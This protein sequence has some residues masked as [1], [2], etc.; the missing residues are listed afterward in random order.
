MYL[1]LKAFTKI[2][3][4]KSQKCCLVHSF[5]VLCIVIHY[6]VLLC[7]ILLYEYY[8]IIYYFFYV[9]INLVSLI[10]RPLQTKLLLTLVFSQFIAYFEEHIVRSAI[11]DQRTHLVV[12]VNTKDFSVLVNSICTPIDKTTNLSKFLPYLIL[13]F[14]F[15]QF[16]CVCR[17]ICI[18]MTTN[19]V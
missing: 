9:E 12:V 15:Q 4:C 16:L 11:A 19:V 10:P 1:C 8:S 6:F 17:G 18:F 5:L 14:K 3:V 7:S 2:Y 13:S